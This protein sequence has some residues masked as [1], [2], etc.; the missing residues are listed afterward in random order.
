MSLVTLS[1]G[2][3]YNDGQFD[4]PFVDEM[5][6]CC[7]NYFD[8]RGVGSAQDVY[9]MMRNG[10]LFHSSVSFSLEDT[11]AILDALVLDR[12]LQVVSAAHLIALSDSLSVSSTP[13][14]S[15]GRSHLSDGAKLPVALE[16]DRD[17]TTD[18]DCHS[19]ADNFSSSLLANGT[20]RQR[21]IH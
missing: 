3:W 15:R 8:Q 2:A 9:D 20:S 21:V 14:V 19:S 13:A 17:T 12:A 10:G 7:L 6:R 5:F 1:G 11:E 18:R 16:Y 4:Q